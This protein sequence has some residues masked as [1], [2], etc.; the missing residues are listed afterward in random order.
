M[1]VF[2]QNFLEKNHQITPSRD[3]EGVGKSSPTIRLLEKPFEKA[4]NSRASSPWALARAT[5]LFAQAKISKEEENSFVV[6]N[7]IVITNGNKIV[8]LLDE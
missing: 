6:Q 8:A 3:F 5:S 7:N 4:K 2:V 1:G